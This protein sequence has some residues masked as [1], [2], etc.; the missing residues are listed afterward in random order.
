MLTPSSASKP[1][2]Y[3]DPRQPVDAGQLQNALLRRRTVVQ[4]VGLSS[5]S[6]D[7][8]VK[9]KTFPAPV[10]LSA[11]CSRWKSEDISAWVRSVGA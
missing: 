11:R 5:S 3:R 6:I 1:K 8:A 2:V 10:R 4:I 7:R 9:A